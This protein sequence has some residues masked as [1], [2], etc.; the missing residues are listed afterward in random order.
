MAVQVSMGTTVDRTQEHLGVTDVGIIEMRKL[1][2]DLVNDLR[3]GRE[4]YA[5]THPEVY[6]GIRG[7]SFMRS[8]DVPFDDCVEEALRSHGQLRQRLEELATDGT[9]AKEPV[10][11]A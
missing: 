11:S 2:L 7:V 1:L 4:P 9:G 5:A 6:A 10:L 8:N 3:D